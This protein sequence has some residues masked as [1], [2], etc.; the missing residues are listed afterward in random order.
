MRMNSS[1]SS[2]LAC[3]DCDEPASTGLGKGDSA[4]KGQEAFTPGPFGR[5]ALFLAAT[6]RAREEL[7]TVRRAADGIPLSEAGF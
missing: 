1:C 6:C 4:P 5:W 3:D 2:V 7:A